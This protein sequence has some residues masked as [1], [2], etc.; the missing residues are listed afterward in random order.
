MNK[1]THPSVRVC[2]TN[3][4]HPTVAAAFHLLLHPYKSAR[5]NYD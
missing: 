5:D 1:V 4:N 3:R 2:H